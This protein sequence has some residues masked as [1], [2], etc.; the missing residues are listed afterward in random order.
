MMIYTHRAGEA[1][2]PISL[3]T[4][5]HSPLADALFYPGYRLLNGWLN[6]EFWERIKE[7]R[8][9]VKTTTLVL[10]TRPEVHIV[11]PRRG[12]LVRRGKQR[13]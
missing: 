6:C 13:F 3:L 7:S 1:P 5:S 8:A 11:V 9:E 12:V 4:W 2:L 10:L